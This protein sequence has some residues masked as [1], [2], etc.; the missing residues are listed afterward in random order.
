[1]PGVKSAGAE[2]GGANV[3]FQPQGQPP[4]APGQEPTAS[5]NIVTPDFLKAM[6]TGLIAGREFRDHDNQSGA[7]VAIISETVAQRYWPNS[8]PLGQHLSIVAR[9][10]S[11]KHSAASAL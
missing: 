5:F 4:A 9:V 7:P 1:M 8:S 6:G 3:F 10:Y 2:G 11:G